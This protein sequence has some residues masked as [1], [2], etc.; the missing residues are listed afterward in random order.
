MFFDLGADK[1]TLL[2][3]GVDQASNQGKGS[4]KKRGKIPIRGS[5]PILAWFPT[6]TPL[7]ETSEGGRGV[8][9]YPQVEIFPLFL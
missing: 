9:F 2:Y 3:R 5:L 6:R 8:P 4:F 1:L 7:G